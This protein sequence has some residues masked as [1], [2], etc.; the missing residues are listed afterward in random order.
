LVAV[1]GQQQTA[2]EV[3]GG[4]TAPPRQNDALRDVETHAQRH[5]CRC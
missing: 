1:T 2:G 3:D 4:G 5:E